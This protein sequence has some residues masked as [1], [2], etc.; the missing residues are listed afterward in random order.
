MPINA[1]YQGPEQLP[2]EIPVFPLAGAILLPRGELPL[3]IFEPRYLAMVEQA[4]AQSR[5]IGMIQPD[6]SRPEGAYGPALFEVGCVGRITQFAETGDGRLLITL[7]GV[8][9]FRTRQEVPTRAP[10]RVCRVAFEPF[11]SDFVEEACG[12]ERREALVDA[13]RRFSK[14]RRIDVDWASVEQASGES[15]VNALSMI[16]PF[17]PAEKQALVEAPSVDDRAAALVAMADMALASMAL[18]PSSGPAAGL[19]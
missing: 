12:A 8:A 18:T 14:A 16:C 2:A 15:L 3:T 11:L 17:D 5:L 1:P 4:M 9:R 7:T 6:D 10:F 13:L 19:Q